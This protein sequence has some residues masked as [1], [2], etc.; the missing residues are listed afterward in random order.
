MKLSTEDLI[1][2]TVVL[3]KTLESPGDPTSP[4]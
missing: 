2:L 4:S 3:E 1:L